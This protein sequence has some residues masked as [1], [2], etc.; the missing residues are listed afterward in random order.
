MI[1]GPQGPFTNLPPAIEAH[2]DLISRLISR[3]ETSRWETNQPGVIEATSQA[4]QEW[5]GEC[6]RVAEGSL[7]KETASWIFGQNVPGKKYALRFYFGGLK[8]FYEAVQKVIDEDFR[9]FMP[10]G[11]EGRADGKGEEAGDT[12]S[13]SARL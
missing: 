5:C 4:E 3:A 6:E 2:V 11:G 13:L 9:G 7:F 10:L 8:G 1:T 12:N